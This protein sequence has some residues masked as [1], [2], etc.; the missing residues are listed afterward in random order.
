MV[1]SNTETFAYKEGVFRFERQIHFMKK[2]HI[3]KDI[4]TLLEKILFV[5]V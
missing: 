2:S 4:C 3:Y 5:D 1:D